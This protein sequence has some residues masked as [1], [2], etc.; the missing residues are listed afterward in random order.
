VCFALPVWR[1]AQLEFIP[2]YSSEEPLRE[3]YAAVFPAQKMPATFSFLC[4]LC[5]FCSILFS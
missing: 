3:F 2:Q 1:E 5:D 4:E